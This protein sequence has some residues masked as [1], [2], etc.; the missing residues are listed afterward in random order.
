MQL[1]KLHAALT[2]FSFKSI[3]ALF[4]GSEL[5]QIAGFEHFLSVGG[6]VCWLCDDGGLAVVDAVYIAW[7]GISGCV[8]WVAAL[9][10]NTWVCFAGCVD[11][12]AGVSGLLWTLEKSLLSMYVKRLYMLYIQSAHMCK[13]LWMSCIHSGVGAGMVSWRSVLSWMFNLL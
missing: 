13:L 2:V 1:A 4:K 7:A 3:Y 5:R 10:L 6:S 11:S 8:A 9:H 12:V